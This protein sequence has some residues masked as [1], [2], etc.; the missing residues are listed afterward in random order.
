SA[1]GILLTYP[2]TAPDLR[3]TIVVTEPL[4]TRQPPPTTPVIGVI[5]A[6]QFTTGVLLPALAKTS[7]RRK[8]IASAGGVSAASAA[9]KFDFQPAS[10]D[11]P[12]LRDAPKITTF[13]ITPRHNTH[14]HLVTEALQAGKHVFVEKP[15]ALNQEELAA[16]GQALDQAPGRHLMVGFNRRFA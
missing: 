7:A 12:P 5:G 8:A 2:E 13:F 10:T 16:V 3:R 11:S 6:G 9:R 4:A 1:L 14:A 15:L